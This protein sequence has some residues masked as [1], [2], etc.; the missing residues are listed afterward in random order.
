MNAKD[1]VR[2]RWLD[3]ALALYDL[4]SEEGKRQLFARTCRSASDRF[5]VKELDLAIMNME[6][7]LKKE[8]CEANE[9]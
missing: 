5:T 4:E 2:Q 3:S 6:Y 8:K 7:L 1:E 9:N